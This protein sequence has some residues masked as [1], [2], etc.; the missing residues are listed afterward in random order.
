MCFAKIM[1]PFCSTSFVLLSSAAITFPRKTCLSYFMLYF[2]QLFPTSISTLIDFILANTSPVVTWFLALPCLARV[3]EIPLTV[4]H[5][6]RKPQRWE[7][8]GSLEQLR[9]GSYLRAIHGQLVLNLG[10]RKV[11][12]LPSASRPIYTITRGHAEH[13]HRTFEHLQWRR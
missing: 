9:K 12:L 1:V 2:I 6:Q 4:L 13:L 8:A 7:F 10:G 11:K 5:M 3:I